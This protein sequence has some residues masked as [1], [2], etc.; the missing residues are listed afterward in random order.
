[1]SNPNKIPLNRQ[2]SDETMWDAV[3]TYQNSG[4]TSPSQQKIVD[5]WN[6]SKKSLS[7]TQQVARE[8]IDAKKKTN[9]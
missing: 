4:K 6:D 7:D 8:A 5:T 1:M 9:N 3:E 2:S